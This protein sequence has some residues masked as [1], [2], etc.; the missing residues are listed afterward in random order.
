MSGIYFKKRQEVNKSG[1]KLDEFIK[2]RKEKGPNQSTCNSYLVRSSSVLQG[3][4]P[5]RSENL[6]PLHV[7]PLL[8]IQ[9]GWIMPIKNG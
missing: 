4:N 8:P 7:Y 9:I 2:P 3:V 5:I 6:Y 1:K